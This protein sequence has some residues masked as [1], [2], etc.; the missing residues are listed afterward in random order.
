MVD[1]TQDAEPSSRRRAS[2]LQRWAKLFAREKVG[3]AEAVEEALRE[4][5]E[6]GDI[7]GAH[8]DQLAAGPWLFLCEGRDGRGE[9]RRHREA[10][11]DRQ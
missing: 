6:A 8:K 11:E 5:E 10:G 4:S 7:G 9:G 2:L 3:S 1:T